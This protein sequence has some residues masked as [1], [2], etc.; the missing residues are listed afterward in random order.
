MQWANKCIAASII[1]L[2]LSGCANTQPPLKVEYVQ[3]PVPYVPDPPVINLPLKEGG[4]EF[5]TANSTAGDVAKHWMYEA[6]YW[7]GAYVI[8]TEAFK[9]Y[10]M[11]GAAAAEEL[12][13]YIKQKVQDVQKK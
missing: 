4:R 8:A 3:V 7:E 6:D 11:K 9:E 10:F 1:V 5:I 12:R 13:E 2:G